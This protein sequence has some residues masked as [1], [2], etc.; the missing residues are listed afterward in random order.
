MKINIYPQR[1]GQDKPWRKMASLTQGGWHYFKRILQSYNFSRKAGGKSTIVS[2]SLCCAFFMQHVKLCH[3]FYRRKHLSSQYLN[4]Q[5]TKSSIAAWVRNVTGRGMSTLLNSAVSYT[6]SQVFHLGFY[7]CLSPVLHSHADD[8]DFASTAWLR[9]STKYLKRPFR[10]KH[11]LWVNLPSPGTPACLLAD[12]WRW[13]GAGLHLL[14]YTSQRT[15]L[16]GK[17]VPERAAQYNKA[18]T[19]FGEIWGQTLC[20]S[21]SVGFQGLREKLVFL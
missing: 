1:S 14:G 20:L 9:K 7:L 19:V 2:Q 15:Y 3:F 11:H 18:K 4:R 16:G 10:K 21:R 12:K 17:A 6:S 5:A 13:E 8:V